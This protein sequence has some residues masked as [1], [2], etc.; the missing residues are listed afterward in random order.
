[1]VKVE[2]TMFWSLQCC[3][4]G[5]GGGGESRKRSSGTAGVVSCELPVI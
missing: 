3:G 2:E 1:M 5:G 4:A